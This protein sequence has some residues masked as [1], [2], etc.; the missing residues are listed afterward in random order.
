MRKLNNLPIV[1]P[2]YWTHLKPQRV[3]DLKT[4]RKHR[5]KKRRKCGRNKKT[6]SKLFCHPLN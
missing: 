3:T 4:C 6:L 1:C 5:K 2:I